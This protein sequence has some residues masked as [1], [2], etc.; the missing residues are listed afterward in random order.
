MATVTVGGEWPAP[1]TD[2]ANWSDVDVATDLYVCVC[3]CSLL[4]Y[5]WRGFLRQI[6][7]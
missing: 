2:E 6:E 7:I 1:L 3:V 5:L 4:L